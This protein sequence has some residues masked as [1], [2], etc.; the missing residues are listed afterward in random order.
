MQKLLLT[1]VQG[2]L[3][4]AIVAHII[5]IDQEEFTPAEL[6]ELIS[7]FL[8][9]LEA[10]YEGREST[11]GMVEHTEGLVEHTEGLVNEMIK[12]G[13]LKFIK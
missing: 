4:K 5:L 3:S 6:I 9:T 13:I 10:L 8:A 11:K 1:D 2:I 12:H 7:A